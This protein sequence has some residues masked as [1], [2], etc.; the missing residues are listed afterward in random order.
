VPKSAQ[1]K[2]PFPA[3]QEFKKKSAKWRKKAPFLALQE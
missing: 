3:E 2:P 1:K